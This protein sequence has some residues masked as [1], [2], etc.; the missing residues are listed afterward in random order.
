VGVV[1]RDS[2][3]MM[4]WSAV[5]DVYKVGTSP[6]VVLERRAYLLQLI[7]SDIVRAQPAK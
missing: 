2:L 1:R 6:E 3:G 5:P 4:K 7:E